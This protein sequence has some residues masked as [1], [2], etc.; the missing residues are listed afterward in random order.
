MQLQKLK[1]YSVVNRFGKSKKTGNEY[2]FFQALIESEQTSY[3]NSEAFGIKLNEVFI[4]EKSFESL[5]KLNTFPVE[6]DA[7]VNADFT[8]GKISIS[9]LNPISK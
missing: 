9:D 6:C 7:Q 2:N 3:T 5:K 4:P 8:T 1:V